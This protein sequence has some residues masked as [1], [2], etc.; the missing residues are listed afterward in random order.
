MSYLVGRQQDDI[1]GLRVLYV[2]LDCC[3]IQET[4]R[5][6]LRCDVTT[7]LEPG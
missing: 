5:D 2:R 4:S 3:Q 1:V 6:A 7:E